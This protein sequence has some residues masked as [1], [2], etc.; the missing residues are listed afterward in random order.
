MI[1]VASRALGR[2]ADI[3]YWA[4]PIG[5]GTPPLPVVLLLH[6]SCASAW[7]WPLNGGAHLTA[8]RLIEAEEIA[9]VAL[10]MPS[11]G[12]WGLGSGYVPHAD[13]DYERFIVEEVPA[14]AAL[15]D[16]RVTGSSP[17]TIAGLSMGGFGALRLGAKYP[18]R[19]RGISAHSAVTT[20]AAWRRRPATASTAYRGSGSRTAPPCT[21]WRSTP[22]AC[23]C[24]ASTAAPTIT[25]CRETA[26][27]T[28]RW[29]RAASSTSTRSSRAATT[30][31]TGAS[32]WRTRCAS[33]T[34]RRR[35]PRAASNS[36][37]FL[38]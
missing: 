3:C 12:L 23:R 27:C 36:C 13:A 33:W 14:A 1:T 37:R 32:T 18:D 11:D 15:A 26:P 6:G 21:G 2:R 20:L 31:R 9:P 29:T 25:C 10:V 7:S 5:T 28:P 17:L 22:R 19:F 24:C 8:G 30:G 35:A 4:P 38:R 16:D 34:G